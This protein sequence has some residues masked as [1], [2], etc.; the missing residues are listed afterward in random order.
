MA[1]VSAAGRTV[2]NLPT[3]LRGP[4]VFAGA[5]GGALIIREVGI[6]NTTTTA[7]AAGIA[8]CTATGT[9]VGGLTE[10][11]IS[12]PSR[13]ASAA[14]AFT[15]QSGDS[16]VAGTIRQASVGAAIGAGVIFTFGELGV[17]ILEGTGNGIII[18]C[19]TGTA[20]HFDFYIDW[21]E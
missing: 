2:T 10:Y 20:Q 18:N 21:D 11:S 19:P 1:R 9:Q 16:T 5:T 3:T 17:L 15:S 6:F 8:V 14:T 4:G 13:P 7:F 12:D